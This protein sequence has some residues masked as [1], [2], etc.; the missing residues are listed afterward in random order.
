MGIYVNPGNNLFEM[1]R[2]FEYYVDKS[3]L[4]SEIN[5]KYRTENISS[6]D[7]FCQ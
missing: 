4:I 3:M 5:K 6:F 1:S 2:N 7:L